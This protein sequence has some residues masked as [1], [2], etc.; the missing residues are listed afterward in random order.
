MAKWK[1]QGTKK[2]KRKR[3]MMTETFESEN[4]NMTNTIIDLNEKNESTEARTVQKGHLKFKQLYIRKIHAELRHRLKQWKGMMSLKD[5]KAKKF[6][7]A[8]L[9]KMKKRFYRDAFDK[10]RGTLKEIEVF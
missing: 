1:V 9:G 7:K 4:Y 8:I 10:F 6:D 3:I 5:H 2:L